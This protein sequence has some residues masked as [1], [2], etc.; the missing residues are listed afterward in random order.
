MAAGPTYEPIATNTLGSATSSVTFSSISGSYTDLVLVIAYKAATTNQPT[1]QLTFNGSSS[2][3]SG[4]QLTGNGSA[5]A[6]YRNT[7][8]AY[9]S[10][11]RLVGVPSTVGNTGTIII[12]LQNY[13][14]TTTYKTVLARANAAD[15]GTEA[16]VG[17]WQNTSAI[18]SFTIAAATSNDFDTGS[19]FTL[20]GILAA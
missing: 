13:S 1:L 19:T 9:I 10:I 3:Y 15:T 14:N 16:D 17:L 5:A 4:T 11:A 12:N 20:Y 7:N 6:S 18:T 2:G 8:A